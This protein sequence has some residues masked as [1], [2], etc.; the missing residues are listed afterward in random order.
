MDY[1]K[2]FS[3]KNLNNIDSFPFK[4]HPE[5]SILVD[6]LSR[7]DQHHVCLGANF[8]AQMHHFLLEA[9]RAYLSS[10]TIP[11]S[12]R[13]A[14]II[15]LDAKHPTLLN[16][17][18]DSI[19]K[20][21]ASLQ[22]TITDKHCLLL[23]FPLMLLENDAALPQIEKLL[24]HPR[25]RLLL[26]T[27]HKPSKHK[28][29]DCFT[30]IPISKPDE[31]D[32]LFML[33]QQRTELEAF[34]HVFIPDELVEFSYL[35]AERYL[36]AELTFDNAL[37]LLDSSAARA[38]V[39]EDTLTRNTLINVLSNWTQ[40]PASHLTLRLLN[41]TDFSPGMQLQLYGQEAAIN[42]LSQK[43]Q[44][45]QPYWEQPCSPFFTFLF[46]G[47]AH[48]GKK[49]AAHALTEQLFKQINVLYYAQSTSSRLNSIADVKLQRSLEHH[50]IS[51]K[52]VIR[53]TPYAVIMF[54]NIER[55][56]PVM[57]DG[58]LEI[59]STGYLHDHDHLYDFR[60]AIIILSTTLGS[61]R[62]AELAKNRGQQDETKHLDWLQLVMSDTKRDNRHTGQRYF[63]QEI[64]QEI[65]P[66]ITTRLPATLCQHLCI[67][68]FLPLTQPIIEKII[69]QKLKMLGKEMN[70]RYGIE[71]G[72]A[73]EVTRFLAKEVL[74]KQHIDPH[75]ADI[76]KALQPLYFSVEQTILSQANNDNR[77]NH[78]F[79]QLNETGQFLKCDFLMLNHLPHSA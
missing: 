50:Y 32:I 12:L 24:S 66:E 53:Q 23:A 75:A 52:D 38:S 69:R 30:Y 33:K 9:L 20:D 77:P 19:A 68:P 14:E 60:Q 43:L 28:L 37:L 22:Q 3:P 71:L 13:N 5:F 35:L 55:A 26:L 31:S 41:L 15:Y 36:S 54:E 79:L 29:K 8:S 39:N 7:K 34:H 47:P 16:G 10:T 42:I 51:L 45:P 27:N 70:V 67:V 57:L 61:E 17:T 59:F 6:T 18:K 78:L 40:I 25:C 4:N 21:F 2:R 1:A 44:Q 49:T 11:Q 73:P 62:L 46:A 76:K 48:S 58:L 65:I 63:P 64:A 72:Y 74:T 56:S